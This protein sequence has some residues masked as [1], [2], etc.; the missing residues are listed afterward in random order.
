MA[1]ESVGGQ[2]GRGP[3]SSTDG[4]GRSNS[5]EDRVGPRRVALGEVLR[6][7]ADLALVGIITTVVSLGVVTAGAAVATASAA[8]HHWSTY[9]SWPGARTNVSRFVRALVPGA[10]ATAVAVVAAALLALDLLWLADGAV[11]GGAV[12]LGANTLIAAGLLGV[13]GL[14]VV[15]VGRTDAHGWRAALRRAL[16]LGYARPVALAAAGGLVALVAVL[17]AL[18]QPITIPILT[19]YA[20][21]ALHATARRLA[22]PVG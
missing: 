4:R 2:S 9:G 10:G 1:I 22:S 6:N 20:L 13:A 16:R 15:E 19:G 17:A 8:V 7:A 11:P 12:V 5:T 18:V 14:T 21:F 3:W